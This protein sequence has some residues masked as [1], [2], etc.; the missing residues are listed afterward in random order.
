MLFRQICLSCLFRNSLINSEEI[1]RQ[2]DLNC[3]RDN[4]SLD[5]LFALL[6]NLIYFSKSVEKRRCKVIYVQRLKL[7]KQGQ[8]LAVHN[9]RNIIT[10]TSSSQLYIEIGWKINNG[11]IVDQDV[12]PYLY[13]LHNAMELFHTKIR[14]LVQLLHIKF[15]VT[16]VENWESASQIINLTR[17]N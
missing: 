3:K 10:P 11:C 15:T 13:E 14:N 6:H 5:N 7:F 8:I 17:Q 4:Q 16:I 2:L 12:V 1:C 9:Q